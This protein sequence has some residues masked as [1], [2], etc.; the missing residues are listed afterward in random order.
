MQSHL[1]GK[2]A[3]M[4][5]EMQRFPLFVTDLGCDLGTFLRIVTKSRITVRKYFVLHS[6][7]LRFNFMHS[8]SIPPVQET[9]QPIAAHI[10]KTIFPIKTATMKGGRVPRKITS[11][12]FQM[13]L[14]S[15]SPC[16]VHTCVQTD[17]QTDQSK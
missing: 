1:A 4:V 11:C 15:S 2:T 17:R 9:L 10:T 13:W 7:I 8:I 3:C 12:V 16:F 6:H 14:I 5:G